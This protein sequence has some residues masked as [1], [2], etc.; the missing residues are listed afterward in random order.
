[1]RSYHHICSYVACGNTFMFKALSQ[2][3][4]LKIALAAAFYGALYFFS[5]KHRTEENEF[6][7]ANPKINIACAIWNLL[8]TQPLAFCLTLDFFHIPH[9]HLIWVPMLD[10]PELFTREN[11]KSL[12]NFSRLDRRSL[13]RQ[14]RM[15]RET[16]EETPGIVYEKS[17]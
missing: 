10:S 1:M 9:N 4:P 3:S 7:L 17:N 15:S 11:V 2:D 13:R 8:D 14:Q 5:G 16:N 6:F 12:G